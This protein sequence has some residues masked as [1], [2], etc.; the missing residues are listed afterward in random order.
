M[1]PR[2]RANYD[3][4]AE[5]ANILTHQADETERLLQDV[6]RCVDALQN[7]GWVGGG[8]DAFYAEMGELVC[9]G[10]QRLMAALHEAS[11]ATGSICQ[12]FQNAESE[13][14]RIFTGE[15]GMGGGA[16]S[17]TPRQ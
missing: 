17:A 2:I 10:L 15:S 14:G 7:G 3:E 11:F 5:V 6:L 12:T 1:A 4:L 16:F 13:A 9:P 8:A